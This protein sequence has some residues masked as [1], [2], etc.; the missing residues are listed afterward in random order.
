MIADG[1]IFVANGFAVGVVATTGDVAD[2]AA[3]I[4]AHPD[5]TASRDEI[6]EWV[7]RN[8]CK[9]D[10]TEASGFFPGVTLDYRR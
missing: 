6:L 4:G 9:L 3:Y 8:G 5:H 7:A 10:E 2:W 1:R